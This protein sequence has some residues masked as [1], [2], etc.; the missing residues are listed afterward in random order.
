[1]SRRLG[2]SKGRIENM[3]NHIGNSVVVTGTDTEIERLVATCFHAPIPEEEDDD[4]EGPQFNFD[5]VIQVP[6]A[7]TD[8][9]EARCR[10]AWGTKWNAYD[11][12]ILHRSSGFLVFEF[13]TANDF[14]EAVYC[15]LGRM[16]PRLDFD[17]VA[18]DPGNWWAVTGRIADGKAAFNR[19]VDCRTVYERV[20]KEPFE[21]ALKPGT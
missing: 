1:M 8:E 17:I 20:F 14:P 6:P 5:A 9:T 15:A 2:L 18:I 12:A 7:G 16:F 19:K 4:D 11:T 3:P 21:A 13:S 10:K